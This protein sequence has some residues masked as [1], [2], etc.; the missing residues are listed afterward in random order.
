ML[1]LDLEHYD[2]RKGSQTLIRASEGTVVDRLPPRIKIR[3]GATLESPHI[4]VLID[5]PEQQVIEPLAKRLG[6]YQKLYD[7]DL[8]MDG[9]HITGYHITD[10]ASIQG[11]IQGLERLADKKH[12]K[13]KYGVSDEAGVLLFAMGDG[14]HSFATAK[15]IREEKKKSLSEQEQ[16]DHPARFALVEL[17][18]I[19][20]EGISFEP[21]HRVLFNVDTT[22]LFQAA[23]KYF[24]SLGSELKISSLSERVS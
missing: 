23:T 22:A 20:D 4:L 15:A 1:A 3:Q 2:Y 18:N 10:E 6:Q 11:V 16:L 14:N 5:D 8:M 17:N 7:F 19:H 21:I 24:T 13:Q 12:F 9:G